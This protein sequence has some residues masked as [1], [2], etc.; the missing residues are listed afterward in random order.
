MDQNVLTFKQELY[1]RTK[2]HL[3]V[4]IPSKIIEFKELGERFYN[5]TTSTTTSSSLDSEES[6]KKRKLDLNS[7]EYT[8][9]PLEELIKT[10]H[11][12][13]KKHKIFKKNYVET[14]EIFSDIR[15][16]ISLNIP[17]IEDGNNIG[18]DIQ[19]DIISQ[20][21]KIEECYTSLLDFAEEYHK[22][23]ARLLK[24]A[25]KHK[26]VDMYRY[27]IARID[28]NEIDRARFGFQDLSQNYCTL[29][30]VIVKNFAKLETPRPTSASNLLN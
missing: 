28:E 21:A 22:V 13:V 23:R 17:K 1:E 8:L 18:V 9:P 19:E 2:I 7:K 6:L 16:W 27:S 3:K 11:S 20:V 29:Y 10:N 4:T 5:E 14:V 30:S 24:K 12:I 25:I 26:D 15:S